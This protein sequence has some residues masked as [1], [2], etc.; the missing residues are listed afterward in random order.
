LIEKIG[1]IFCNSITSFV[2]GGD[3]VNDVV[4]LVGLIS[5]HSRWM[6][7]TATTDCASDFDCDTIPQIKQEQ[8]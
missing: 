8:S 5:S 4:E 2:E 3:K 7:S 1:L 6:A